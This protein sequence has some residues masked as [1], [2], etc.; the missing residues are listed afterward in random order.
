MRWI[1]SLKQMDVQIKCLLGDS[2]FAAAY[3][4]YA[5]AFTSD[6]RQRL[7]AL[8]V[9]K[10]REVGFDTSKQK[11]LAT[12]ILSDQ[13]TLMNYVNQYKLPSDQHSKENAAMLF[14]T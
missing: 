11:P 1:E 4:I 13:V 2:L 7:S 8:W 3:V 5:G 14:T 6:F 12:E 9:A 10:I